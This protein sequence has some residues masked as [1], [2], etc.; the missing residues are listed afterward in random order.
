MTIINIQMTAL[1][2]GNNHATIEIS[3]DGQTRK[4]ELGIDEI[5]APVTADDIETFARLAIKIQSDGKT[6]AQLRNVLQLGFLVTI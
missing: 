3:K 5:R 2:A 4:L 6:K 1:C